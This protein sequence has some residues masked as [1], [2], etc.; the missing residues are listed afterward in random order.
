MIDLN[1][2]KVSFELDGEEEATLKITQKQIP[3]EV[4]LTHSPPFY[5]HKIS[6]AGSKVEHRQRTVCF[7]QHHTVAK[8]MLSGSH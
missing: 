3:K 8:Q 5:K 4:Q 6:P 7:T 2:P 1:T